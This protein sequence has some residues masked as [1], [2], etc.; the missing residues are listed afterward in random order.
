MPKAAKRMCAQPGCAA[1]VSEGQYCPWHYHLTQVMEMGNIKNNSKKFDRYKRGPAEPG[2]R[3][4][5]RRARP[6]ILLERP[7][8]ASCQ[9]AGHTV[10]ATV[11]DHVLP[12]GGDDAMFWD[13]SNWQPLCHDCFSSKMSRRNGI[14]R[15]ATGGAKS[16]YSTTGK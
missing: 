7:L 14:S 2:N 5:W 12:H 16:A 11:V 1:V 4:R 6:P 8:C 13:V 15:G 10:S 3:A 9:A